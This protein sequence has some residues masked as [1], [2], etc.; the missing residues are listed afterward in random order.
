MEIQISQLGETV[1]KFDKDSEELRSKSQGELEKQRKLFNQLKDL[2]EDYILLQRK[3]ANVSQMMNL[4]ENKLLI[5]GS[6]NVILKKGL[7]MA[8]GRI[9]TF[10]IAI[11][12][13][14]S[15]DTDTIYCSDEESATILEVNISHKKNAEEI[16]VEDCDHNIVKKTTE[17]S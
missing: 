11:H 2:K 12:S 4:L 10:Q 5:T 6:E 8:L 7:E 1:V 14:I 16:D 9:C 3:E 13:E 17:R 15:S